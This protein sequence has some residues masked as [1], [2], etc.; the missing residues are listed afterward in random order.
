[1]WYRIC[2]SI[3]T[4][5]LIS[6][7]A[8]GVKHDFFNDNLKLEAEPD[9]SIVVGTLDHRAYVLDSRKNTAFTGLSR[10]GFGN[11]FDVQTLS[12]NPLATDFSRSIAASLAKNGAKTEVV[13]L[14]H[15]QSVTDASKKL[16]AR[17]ADRALLLTL[18]E[19][20]GDSMFNVRLVY[21]FDLR[22]LDQSGKVLAK[23]ALKGDE[24]LGASDPIKPGG[25]EQISRRFKGLVQSLFK[26]DEITQ[27]LIGTN[28]TGAGLTASVTPATNQ[29]TLEPGINGTYVS[30]ITKS[31][32]FANQYFTKKAHQELVI[33]LKKSGNTITGTDSDNSAVIEGTQKGDRI[34]FTFWSPNEE[35]T[36]RLELRGT[37][38]VNPDGYTLEGKWWMGGSTDGTW[39]LIKID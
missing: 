24:N 31:G 1:M 14:L 25:G 12:G 5:T 2:V 27:Q 19:W 10:G 11:P 33:T 7:C 4:V 23:N 39:D 36:N 21:D 34:D 6:G 13:P 15:S 22:I 3:V 30:K 9:I 28:G 16:I 26:D 38:K 8:V 37:W 17:G 35:I 32:A 18:R 20:K 29:K